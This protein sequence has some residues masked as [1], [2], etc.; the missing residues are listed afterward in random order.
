MTIASVMSWAGEHWLLLGLALVTLLILMKVYRRLRRIMRR[1]RPVR[2]H[3]KLQKY[4]STG[5]NPVP[6]EPTEELT[7]QRRAE[8][9]HII[10]TSSTEAIA[11][12]EIMEQV[13]AVYVDGFIRP[14]EALEGLKAVA[15]MKGANAMTN[16]RRER[17]SDRRC[18]ASG[19]AVI[20]RK[21][22]A[23]VSAEPPSDAAELVDE[24]SAG[25][26][27]E[28]GERA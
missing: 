20:V 8:A 10:A 27:D 19:D 2:L 1:R 12:Y 11:G 7:A 17:G 3:P 4:G 13:E 18:S 24:D 6:H 28:T 14:E 25:D 15:A 22:A 16:V 9:E 21:T 5:W 23:S 26:L